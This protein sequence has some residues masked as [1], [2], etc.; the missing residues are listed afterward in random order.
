MAAMMTSVERIAH[1]ARG[2]KSEGSFTSVRTDGTIALAPLAAAKGAAAGSERAACGAIRLDTWPSAGE[3]VF[4]GVAV[5]YRD[6][7][8]VV[9]RDVTLRIPG[10]GC[11]VGIVGRTGSGKSTL[12]QALCRLNVIC[13]GRIL[14]D[15]VD[16]SSVGLHE[17]RG[18]IAVIPQQPSVFAGSVRANV[19]PFCRHSDA[20]VSAVL[21]VLTLDLRLAAR[22]LGTD[23]GV[24]SAVT[25]TV[26]SAGVGAC[27]GDQPGDVMAESTS[28]T[29]ARLDD[30]SLLELSLSEGGA[31]LS[32]GER[33]LLSLARAMLRAAA[34]VVLDE[35]TANV[36]YATDE[37][38]QRTLRT[39]ECFAKA[40]IFTIAHRIS[41]VIDSDMIVVVE[42]GTIAESGAVRELLDDPNSAFAKLVGPEQR[43]ALLS[44]LAGS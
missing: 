35:A 30:S 10:G 28:A 7:L 31:N 24:D 9:L 29:P 16:V 17:L 37:T 38:L 23:G 8:P 4:E 41:T 18:N 20:E 2:V 44:G 1:Y 5:R 42:D 21:R 22:R 6:D 43:S 15:G 19:D 34:I 13:G 11:R 36:D 33:Q 3:V 14:I 27:A 26:A 32:V 12:V 40:T 39:S 25:V